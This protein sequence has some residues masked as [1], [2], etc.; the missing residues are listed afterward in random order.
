MDRRRVARHTATA[1]PEY[2][3]ELAAS[4]AVAS[5]ERDSESPQQHLA[6]SLTSSSYEDSVWQQE[7]GP[8]VFVPFEEMSDY[9][10]DAHKFWMVNSRVR[11][12][13]KMAGAERI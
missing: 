10:G 8:T 3:A 13:A 2:S 7:A 12:L 9:F 4:E 6:I 1:S 11:N 5:V